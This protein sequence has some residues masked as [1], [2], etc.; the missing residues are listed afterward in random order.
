VTAPRIVGR[1]RRLFDRLPSR[2]PK[3]IRSQLSPAGYL[4]ADY[5]VAR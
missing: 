2:Q 3:S 5:R 4:L 1:G